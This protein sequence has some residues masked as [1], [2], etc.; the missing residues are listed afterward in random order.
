MAGLR[1][2][3][4]PT[5]A[6]GFDIEQSVIEGEFY[7]LILL[8]YLGGITAFEELHIFDQGYRKSSDKFR[9]KVYFEVATLFDMTSIIKQVSHIAHK[10]LLYTVGDGDIISPDND[11][12]TWIILVE[13]TFESY[14]P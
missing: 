5:I 11:R 6:N 1:E 8:K 2:T 4:I 14:I 10:D 9:A 13:A 3:L 12:W 7:P